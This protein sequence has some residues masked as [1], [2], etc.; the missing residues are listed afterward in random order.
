MLFTV[1]TMALAAEA[2]LEAP[3][4]LIT[5][6][7]RFC[8]V[9]MNGPFEPCSSVMASVAAA[10]DRRVIKIRKLRG[11]VIAP[12]AD[13]FHLGHFDARLFANCVAARF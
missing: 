1:S 5:A 11:R 10:V 4:A 12:D 2:A 7:P 8:T 3:R 9:S 6:P 13:A